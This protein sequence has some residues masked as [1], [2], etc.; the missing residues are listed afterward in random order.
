MSLRESGLHVK[1]IVEHMEVQFFLAFSGRQVFLDVVKDRVH[2][3]QVAVRVDEDK[4]AA[5]LEVSLVL[6]HFLVEVRG[7]LGVDLLL[8]LVLRVDDRGMARRRENSKPTRSIVVPSMMQKSRRYLC[9]ASRPP[10]R[11][12]CVRPA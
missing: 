3:R 4:D 5:F 10:C 6:G 8:R 12:P 7:G 9:L 11:R 1:E 2:V